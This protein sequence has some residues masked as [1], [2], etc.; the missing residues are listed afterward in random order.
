M[1]IA[2]GGFHHETNTFAPSKADF[3]AFARGGA[4]PALCRGDALFESVSGVN[5]PVAGFIDEARAGGHQLV[6]LSWAA[7]TPSDRVTE[8]AYERIVGQMLEDLAAARGLDGL[9][10]DL[11]GAMV[12]E[13]HQDG[14]G[15]LL[16]RVRAIVG[17]D[18][19]VVVSL[20]LH[21]NVTPA[22]VELADALVAYRTYPHV[23]MAVTGGRGYRLLATLMSGRR[24]AKVRKALPFLIPLTSGCSFIEPA[25]GLYESIDERERVPGVASLSFAA[26]FSPADIWHC[27][28]TVL[29]FGEDAAATEAAAEEL[30]Q[31]ILA[32]EKGFA[33][34]I[35]SAEQAVAHAIKVSATAQRPVVLADTQ[36]NPGAG[37]NGDTV[38]LLAELVRQ[39]APRAVI[40]LLFDPAAAERA[41]AAGEGATIEIGL[42]SHSG[43]PGHEPLRGSYQVK[44]L[45]DGRFECTGPFYRGARMELGPMA[46]LEIGGV[47]VAVASRKA[48]LADR[49][50][51]R[52]VSVDPEER[53]IV[54]VKSSVHFRADFQ[55][56]AE[57]VVVAA[58]PGPNPVDH[59]QLDYRFLRPGVRLMPTG[60]LSQGPKQ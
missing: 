58:A 11:H 14:E 36:D 55:P 24:L 8:D 16:R 37:G 59:L 26:G 4:W 40:G 54:A 34:T 44:K 19:P 10:L 6:P 53:G 12:T 9:Y 27:G 50:M 49:E 21:A 5:L 39:R 48:Q 29:A 51:L 47:E 22:M 28:P 45:G 42:G 3:D 30:Y 1:K 25:K 23:D 18:L 20:D 13:H 52:H 17:K 38:G 43:L 60:P 15:E 57:Q 41:H 32:Q 35:M 7:A 46:L 31:A 56:I 2:V 33:G